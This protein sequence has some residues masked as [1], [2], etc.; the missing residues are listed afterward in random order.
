MKEETIF[1]VGEVL[2]NLKEVRKEL[3]VEGNE[4]WIFTNGVFFKLNE[5]LLQDCEVAGLKKG[6]YM[7]F[8]LNPKKYHNGEKTNFSKGKYY[9]FLPH[10]IDEETKIENDAEFWSY[11]E[12]LKKK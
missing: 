10:E 4:C 6:A 12:T 3:N 7:F 5:E 11:F 2:E 8:L 9:F 1:Y